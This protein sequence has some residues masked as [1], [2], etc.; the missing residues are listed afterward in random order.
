M[1]ERFD[2]PTQDIFLYLTQDELAEFLG[3]KGD[4]G[5]KEVNDEKKV[6]FILFRDTTSS[7]PVTQYIDVEVAHDVLG[8]EGPGY[9]HFIISLSERACEDLSANG[10]VSDRYTSL[11]GSEKVHIIVDEN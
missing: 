9:S 3:T 5:I 2:L 4:E 11:T 10:L 7:Q 6:L 8:K 1:R